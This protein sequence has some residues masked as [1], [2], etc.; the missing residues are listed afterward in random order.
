MCSLKDKQ[1]ELDELRSPDMSGSKINTSSDLN[2]LWFPRKYIN[3]KFAEMTRGPRRYLCPN[4]DLI[5][6][7][8]L[9]KIDLNRII[10]MYA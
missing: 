3:N 8:T 4:L 10:I 9:K 7:H 1:Y 2:V 6:T 5:N